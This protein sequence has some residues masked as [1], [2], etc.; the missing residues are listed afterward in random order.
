MLA[1]TALNI[2]LDLKRRD[3]A[4]SILYRS[5]S[6]RNE[7][8]AQSTNFEFRNRLFFEIPK[9]KRNMTK[10]CI[11]A[12][13]SADVLI[14]ADLYRAAAIVPGSGLARAYDEI[15]IEYVQAFVDRA[16]NNGVILGAFIDSDLVG[17]IH[18]TRLG[19]RQFDHVLGD[20]TVAVHPKAQGQGVGSALLN[21]FFEKAR[22][23]NPVVTG[24]ELT[25]RS[26]NTGALR[27]YERLGFKAEGR[28]L[29]RVKLP[30]GSI[31]DDIPMARGIAY[32]ED[33]HSV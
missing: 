21:A 1:Q 33:L 8:R 22:L 16:I 13:A 28:L 29:G 3:R 9:L 15:S 2:T 18:A 19:P 32:P 26:G 4:R 24:V 5:N 12:L 25:A 31:E 7:E 17:E 20:L 6:D 27:L 30:D 10:I 11:N 23:I 14:I